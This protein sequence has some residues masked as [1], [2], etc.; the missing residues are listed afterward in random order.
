MQFVIVFFTRQ[1]TVKYSSNL[2]NLLLQNAACIT[3]RFIAMNKLRKQ[4]I[5]VF[6]FSYAL[7]FLT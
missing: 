1:F 7:T 3:E 6:F 5:K 2:Q 4:Y